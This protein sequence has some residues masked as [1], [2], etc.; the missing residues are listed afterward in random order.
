[1]EMNEEF[2]EQMGRA[3]LNLGTKETIS[4]MARLMSAIAQREGT[5]LVFECDLGKVTIQRHK[6]KNHS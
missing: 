2:C 1:M 5:D 4:C 3:L 6:I